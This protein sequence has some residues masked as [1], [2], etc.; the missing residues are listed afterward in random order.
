MYYYF[1]YSDYT[2]GSFSCSD[3]YDLLLYQKLTV[4]FLQI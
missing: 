1:D 2:H 3:V 4:N